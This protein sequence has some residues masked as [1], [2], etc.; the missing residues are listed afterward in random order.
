MKRKWELCSIFPSEQ[1]IEMKKNQWSS[2]RD[3]DEKI[4][5]IKVFPLPPLLSFHLCHYFHILFLSWR[6]TSVVRWK[7]FPRKKYFRRTKL[8][9][10]HENHENLQ[11]IS[12]AA[13]LWSWWLCVS[14]K[15][16]EKKCTE[17]SWDKSWYSRLRREY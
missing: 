12:H 14:H 5:R 15:W 7:I 9:W 8:T 1:R 6:F 10:S 17:P 4:T 2:Q 3:F 16:W 13:F 11:N